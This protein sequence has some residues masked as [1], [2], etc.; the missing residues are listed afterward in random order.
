MRYS[1]AVRVPLSVAVLPAVLATILA[2][3]GCPLSV[4][5]GGKRCDDTH[6]C[7]ANYACV[8]GVCRAHGDVLDAGTADAG[9]VADAGADDAGSGEGEGEGAGDAG[10]ADAGRADGGV[11]VPAA[12]GIERCNNFDDNCVGGADEGCDNGC[13]D[14]AT[15]PGAFFSLCAGPLDWQSARVACQRRGLDLAVLTDARFSDAVSAAVRASSAGDDAWIGATDIAIEHEFAW[16][17]DSAFVFDDFQAGQPN[18]NSGQDCAASTASGGWNDLSCAE[19]HA[20]VCARPPPAVSYTFCSGAVVDADGDGAPCDVD[21]DDGDDTVFP[22]AVELCGDRVDNDCDGV[23][24]E[25][26]AACADLPVGGAT[27][28]ERITFWDEA[29]TRCHERGLQLGKIEGQALENAVQDVMIADDPGRCWIGLNDVVTEGVNVWDDGSA[30]GA[31]QP[32]EPTQPTGVD[33]ENCF[34]VRDVQPAAVDGGP[35]GDNVYGWGDEGCADLRGAYL[36][37]P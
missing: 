16:V 32:F 35:A 30:L 28:C 20:F 33:S 36:C 12:D 14:D 17:D 24:D 21:C 1:G 2:A 18:D 26:C 23:V 31:F 37:T 4:G 7:I 34:S 6:A 13:V 3:T 27:L 9:D 22:G 15:F 8:D 5:I 29:R 19:S 11:C 25:G 10:V